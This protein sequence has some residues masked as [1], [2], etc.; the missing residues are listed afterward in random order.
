MRYAIESETARYPV[1]VI[2]LAMV[3][4]GC[5]L[6]LFLV[7]AIVEKAENTVEDVEFILITSVC[8]VLAA[9]WHYEGHHLVKEIKKG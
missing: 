1:I 5:I 6:K 4:S 7:R 8:S 3:F 2:K 9:V